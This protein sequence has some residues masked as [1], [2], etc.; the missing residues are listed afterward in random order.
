MLPVKV[1]GANDVEFCVREAG[2]DIYI[3]ACK[4][5]GATVKV[6]FSGLPQVKGEGEVMF[7]SPRTVQVTDGKYVDWFAP[8]DVHVY[9]FRR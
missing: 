6:E 4:R 8:F 5:E 2:R 9:H 7:E 3:I 1:S